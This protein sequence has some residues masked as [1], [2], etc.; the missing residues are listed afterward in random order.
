[1]HWQQARAASTLLDELT[2]H[3]MRAAGAALL[4]S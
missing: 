4:P 2:R 1:L 3:L